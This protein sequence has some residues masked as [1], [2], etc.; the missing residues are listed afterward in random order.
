MDDE[1]DE[2][3]GQQGEDGNFSSH[4]F[5]QSPSVIGFQVSISVLSHLRINVRGPG[6]DATLHVDDVVQTFGNEELLG[7]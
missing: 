3:T 2:Q 7:F 1:T 4:K 6:M 5:D